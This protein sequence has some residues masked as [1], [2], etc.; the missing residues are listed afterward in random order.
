M[1][2]FFVATSLFLVL[3]AC[4]ET[5]TVYVVDTLPDEVTTT[6]ELA[7]TT[8]KP[9]PTTTVSTYTPSSGIYSYREELFLDGVQAAYGS[10]IYVSDSDLVDMAYVICD[11]LDTGVSLETLI[12][13]VAAEMSS[14]A[15]AD[16]YQFVTAIMA[17]AI[18]NI[19]PQHQWQI[20][21][22]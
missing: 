22:N 6:T 12:T 2:K 17:S 3:T 18:V 5:K 14:Y 7:P 21:N 11:T 16:T 20:P 13:V 4:G 15:T 19:C 8:T 1:K 10:T 9:R